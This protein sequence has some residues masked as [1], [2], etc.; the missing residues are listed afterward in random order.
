M[1]LDLLKQIR[2]MVKKIYI[3]KDLIEYINDDNS[4]GLIHNP[5]YFESI[6]MY[7][8][9]TMQTKEDL[10]ELGYDEDINVKFY[11]YKNY[12][13][14]F[15]ITDKNYII[16]KRFI[17]NGD[18]GN[19]EDYRENGKPY[20]ITYCL[21]EKKWLEKW[22]VPKNDNEPCFINDGINFTL[23]GFKNSKSIIEPRHITINKKTGKI[24]KIAF[25]RNKK[26]IATLEDIYQNNPDLALLFLINVTHD[27][28]YSLIMK[29]FEEEIKI[30]EMM[31]I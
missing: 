26:L 17:N 23:L 28:A 8:K 14:Q 12:R 4:M 29:E 21:K 5:I 3:E 22:L 18:N 1:N 24:F 31:Y 20:R 7:D 9:E 6:L 15:I 11:N 25:Y 2:I 19:H 27:N 16:E 10:I 13:I 30:I